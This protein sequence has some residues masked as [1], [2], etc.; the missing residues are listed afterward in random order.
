MPYKI[1]FS[2]FGLLQLKT[3]SVSLIF[4]IVRGG[5]GW[6]GCWLCGISEVN[7]IS[8]PLNSPGL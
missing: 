2:T 1:F 4:Y 7:P 5:G 8:V 6:V 3:C